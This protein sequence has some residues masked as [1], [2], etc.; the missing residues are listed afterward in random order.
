[1]TSR[2]AICGAPSSCCGERARPRDGGVAVILLMIV[3]WLAA[4]GVLAGFVMLAWLVA[5]WVG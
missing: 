2:F 3:E 1:M 5:Q 4:I